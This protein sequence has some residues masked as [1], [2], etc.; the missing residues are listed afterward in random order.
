MNRGLR[1]ANISTYQTW[2]DMKARCYN[3]N[4]HNYQNYG[5]RGISV[6][7]RWLESFE[8]FF[9]D[10]GA[11]PNGL[12]LERIDVNGNYE[13]SNC[14]WAD[15]LEQRWNQRD[16]L[17][18]RIGHEEKPVEAWARS[19]GVHAETI[20]RRLRAGWDAESAVMAP[21]ARSNQYIKAARAAKAGDQHG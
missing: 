17:M 19:C 15:R 10:M 13:P 8:N 12:T 20:R 7:D 9:A 6:C 11:K 3:K 2:Q 18:L 4:C 14:K 21:A 1:S 5:A 16:V